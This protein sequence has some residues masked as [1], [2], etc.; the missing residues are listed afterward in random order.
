MATAGLPHAPI[1]AGVTH[2]SPALPGVSA[3]YI[4]T[5]HI[6][7]VT[8]PSKLNQPAT[9]T[10]VNGQKAQAHVTFSDSV[11]EITD[12]PR[13]AEGGEQNG[14]K[15]P[16]PPPPRKSSRTTVKNLSPTHGQPKRPFSP[17]AYENIENLNINVSGPSDGETM[18]GQKQ[19]PGY[20]RSISAP[21]STSPQQGAIAQLGSQYKQKPMSKFQQE[22][23]AGIYAN[24][25]RP[26][27]QGQRV[28]HA[29]VVNDQ[30]NSKDE[31]QVRDFSDNESTTSSQD[32][33][34]GLARKMLAA[35]LDQGSPSNL[36]QQSPP[37]LDESR[38]L[39]TSASS[40]NGVKM[41]EG[42]KVPPPP[43]IRRTSQ[44]SSKPD[45]RQTDGS[46]SMTVEEKRRS[47]SELQKE[48]MQQI[49]RQGSNSSA[50]A[51]GD[52]NNV[53]LE[54]NGVLPY[55]QTKHLTNGDIIRTD[56]SFAIYTRATT[57]TV[58]TITA[59]TQHKVTN[60]HVQKQTGK[61]N[62]TDIY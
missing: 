17:P 23:A 6:G 57:S 44:L 30:N 27:L 59:T 52:R 51:P 28:N 53:T 12:T 34:A 29:A 3:S 58:T 46:D 41:R 38:D 21:N 19:Q 40:T 50:V 8:S 37:R 9:S 60:V 5:P 25:N 47:V 62:E 36:R 7:T 16:P 11:I 10:P 45:N 13:E 35:K 48:I 55:Q 26:D 18:A 54:R 43:P 1:P 15:V 56:A 22:L 39:N 32:S 42:K 2:T 24:M 20:N 49:E 61:K 31:S 14:K 4:P 33:Q